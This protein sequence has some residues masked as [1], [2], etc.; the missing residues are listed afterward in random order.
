MAS[1]RFEERIERLEQRIIRIENRLGIEASSAAKAAESTARKPERPP[2]VARLESADERLVEALRA[3][4]PQVTTPEF[5][6]KLGTE[7]PPAEARHEPP[8]AGRG[9]AKGPPRAESAPFAPSDSPLA[10]AAHDQPASASR[11]ESTAGSHHEPAA[12]TEGEWLE[13]GEWPEASGAEAAAVGSEPKHSR[14]DAFRRLF[15]ASFA[16][17]PRPA[18]ASGEYAGEHGG[19]PPVPPRGGGARAAGAPEGGGPSWEMLIGTRWMAWLGA[20]VV[21]IAVGF[22][23]KLAVDQGWWGALPKE[24]RCGMAAGLG[25]LLIAAG[26]VALRRVG[27]PAAVGLFGAGLGTLYLTAYAGARYFEL[28]SDQTAFVLM[29]VVAFLGFGV[30]TRGRMLAIGVL[31]VLGGYL[32]PILLP[33]ESTIPF[34]FP[35]YLTMLLGVSLGLSAALPKPFVPLRYVAIGAHLLMAVAWAMIERDGHPWLVISFMTLW[36][37]A[38]HA[39]AFWAARRERSANGNALASILATAWYVAVSCVVMNGAQAAGQNWLG[40]FTAGVAVLAAGGALLASSGLDVL[41]QPPARAIDKFA[42]TLWGQAGVLAALAIALHFN[43]YG[44]N[45]YGQTI[46]WLAMGLACVEVGRRLRSRGVDVFGLIVGSLALLRVATVD[47]NIVTLQRELWAVQDVLVVT[48]WMI[49]ALIATAATHAAAWRFRVEEKE[50]TCGIGFQP[51]AATH[52]AIRRIPIVLAAL[53]VAGWFGAWAVSAK[54][55]TITAAWLAAP[56]ALLAWEKQGRRLQFMPL[57]LVALVATAS[58]WMIA[59]VAIRRLAPGFDPNAVRPFVNA[60]MGL[61]VAIGAVG[62]WVATKLMKEGRD[63]AGGEAGDEPGESVAGRV[64]APLPESHPWQLAVL[65]VAA[66]LLL[67]ASFEIDTAVHL[68]E[69]ADRVLRF[70]TG[71]ALSLL[72]TLAWTFGALGLAGLAVLFGTRSTGGRLHGVSLLLRAAW[73]VLAICAGKF[74]VV[75]TIGYAL[76]EAGRGGPIP[77]PILNLQLLAAITL[78]GAVLAMFILTG[79]HR[80]AAESLRST[81]HDSDDSPLD[82][83]A[84]L[85]SQTGQLAAWLPVASCLLVLWGLTFEVDRAVTRYVQV[86]GDGSGTLWPAMQLRMLWVTLLWAAGG[87]GMLVYG[88][89]RTWRPMLQTGC[90]LLL[91][92]AAA[93]LS[94]DTVGWR[95]AGTR[96]AGVLPLLNVQFAIGAMLAGLL[97]FVSRFIRR[98]EGRLD[99]FDSTVCGLCAVGVAAIGLWLGSLEIDR[100]CMSDLYNISNPDMVRQMCFSIFWS[101]YAIGLVTYGFG[102]RLRLARYAGLGLFGMTLL[103]VMVIDLSSVQQIY[104]VFSLLGVGLL[105]VATSIAYTKLSSRLLGERV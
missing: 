58:K 78:G 75:D 33:A 18:A 55:L 3:L 79:L 38:V 29:A 37:A 70:S 14:T 10:A 57:A 11:P 39:E 35:M 32:T 30:T 34:A 56:V 105:L 2:A 102:R 93:W 50:G 60:Q 71:H 83:R 1:D 27:R 66:V 40:V 96:P 86:A 90:V 22:F 42:V 99:A 101:L 98:G 24:V 69:T 68:A 65:G 81:S 47:R 21:V 77:L 67:G 97:V 44:R 84:R 16:S 7:W 13:A 8:A 51:V 61:A 88:K 63:V 82:F 85:A 31:S 19:P 53:S 48:P 100:A 94:F 26:E 5:G 46:G 103:K 73:F 59:D 49:L 43:D 28:F 6:D 17:P 4:P 89:L 20:I 52:E 64:A 54:E 9:V 41:R 15:P 92:G 25:A 87:V 91:A 36:W 95:I 80:A 62:W 72:L 23:V 12:A 74:L 76:T 45:D 104:R